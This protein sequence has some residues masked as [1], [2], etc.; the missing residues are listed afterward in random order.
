VDIN[1][2]ESYIFVPYALASSGMAQYNLEGRR[3]KAEGRRQKA[4]GRRQKAEGR[5]QKAEGR[6]FFNLL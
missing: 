4:E 1:H 6:T 2:V 3:Q 5:R